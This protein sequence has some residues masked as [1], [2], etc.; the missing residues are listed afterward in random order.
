MKLIKKIIERFDFSIVMVPVSPSAG[1]TSKT[2]RSRFIILTLLI[3][4]IVFTAGLSSLWLYTPLINLIPKSYITISEEEKTDV[5]VI[6]KK[7]ESLLKEIDI[8]KNSNER[9]KKIILSVDSSAFLK[10]NSANSVS[11]KTGGNIMLIARY[12]Y[13]TWFQGGDNPVFMKPVKGFVTKDFN[14]GSGHFGID[15]AVKEGTPIFA[16]AN[17]YVVFANFTVEDGYTIIMAHP[18][19]YISVYKHCSSLLKKERQSVMQGEIIALSG[20]TGKWSTGPHL[21]FEIW[22]NGILI[23][24]KTVILNK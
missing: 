2:F 10:P 23:D 21:H 7:I 22:K 12:V 1:W 17:G 14:P 20:N 3:A 15:F 9:L 13:S 8:L 19:N 5:Y 11:K 24:P 16:T 18:E 6:N 4:L